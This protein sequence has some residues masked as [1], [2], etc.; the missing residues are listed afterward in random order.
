GVGYVV[1]WL[2]PDSSSWAGVAG[3]DRYPPGIG[4]DKRERAIGA[5]PPQ[6]RTSMAGNQGVTVDGKPLEVCRVDC[7]EWGEVRECGGSSKHG[8]R[9]RAGDECWQPAKARFTC[10]RHGDCC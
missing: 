6:R 10:P 7:H 2:G 9:V 4:V 8:G 3:E 1:W 5:A